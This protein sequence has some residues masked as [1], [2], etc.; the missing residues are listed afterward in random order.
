MNTALGNGESGVVARKKHVRAPA[1]ADRERLMAGEV[2]PGCGLAKDRPEALVAASGRASRRGREE[3]ADAW[4]AA[5]GKAPLLSHQQ[6]EQLACRIEQGDRQAREELLNANVRL[7][8]SIARRYQNR[9]LP[10]D[11]LMQE[12]LI[13]LMR[14]I[15]KYNYRKGYRFS[16][17][18]THWIRQAVTRALANQSRC[19][20]LPAHIVDAIG[21]ITRVREELLGRLGRI[22]TRLEVATE[23]GITEK[24]LAL[25][26]R[27]I[28]QPVSLD[29]MVGDDGDTRLGDFLPAPEEASPTAR[30]LTY[31]V[32][33]EV[34]RALGV[35]TPRERDVIVLRFGLGTD[36]P[37]TL[38]ETGRQLKITRERARQIEAKALEKLRQAHA[39]GEILETIN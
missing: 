12:G 39:L 10:L 1:E 15:E 28:P 4:M 18:A 30:L 24:K 16:T 29:A 27:S 6:E 23:A 32:R 8:A 17:Y 11:D 14:A 9:G 22:P 7:V 36:E 5:S 38:E 37:C 34:A 25:L 13:G 2:E 3:P 31:L 26:I 19:I 21:R 33:E 35:L 20:R